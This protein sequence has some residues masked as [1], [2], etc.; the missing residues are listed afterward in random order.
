ME[1]VPCKHCG[2][3]PELRESYSRRM[4]H[5]ICHEIRFGWSGRTNVITQWNGHNSQPKND[6][7]NDTQQLKDAKSCSC[8]LGVK[9]VEE[10]IG[11][12]SHCGYCGGAL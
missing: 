9:F 2:K 1:I 4:I 6:S 3:V 7:Q 8:G 10:V 11:E 5:H 12:Y